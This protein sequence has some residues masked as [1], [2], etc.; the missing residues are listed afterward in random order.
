MSGGA[1]DERVLILPRDY[2]H[3]GGFLRISMELRK[4]GRYGLINGEVSS[5]KRNFL[6]F[7]Y[8][9]DLRIRGLCGI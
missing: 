3:S 6:H 9:W 7:P 4:G 5:L 2:R 1:D 8:C